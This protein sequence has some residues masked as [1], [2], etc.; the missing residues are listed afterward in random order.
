MMAIFYIICAPW[1]L[2][3]C[4]GKAM[5]NKPLMEKRENTA[6]ID[7]LIGKKIHIKGDVTFEGGLRLDG[8]IEGNI[9]V[10]NQQ[11]ATLV[12]SENAHVHGQIRVSHLVLNGH[13]EGDVFIDHLVELQPKAHIK[14][15][16]HYVMLEMHQGAIV[17]GRLIHTPSQ[18]PDAY[19]QK[20]SAQSALQANQAQAIGNKNTAVVASAN[21]A[22]MDIQELN[23]MNTIPEALQQKHGHTS[24]LHTSL[25][26]GDSAPAAESVQHLQK[27]PQDFKKDIKDMFGFL[28]KNS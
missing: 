1:R 28:K 12:I 18:N 21:L 22:N 13:V 19:A 4:K 14:G 2:I 11:A 27:E 3:T 25:M 26:D 23:S 17:E 5:F 9:N 10:A 24:T 8:S 6:T 16:V 20:Q 15:D 7:S